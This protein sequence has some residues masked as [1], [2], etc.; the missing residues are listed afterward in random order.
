MTKQLC[1]LGAALATAL[2]AVGV[3]GTT[4]ASAQQDTSW[5]NG[6]ARHM[7]FSDASD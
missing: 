2:L 7:T 1:R 5:G 3:L 4:P 6:L